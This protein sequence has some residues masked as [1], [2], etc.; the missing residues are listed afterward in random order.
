MAIHQIRSGTTH[1]SSSQKR[2]GRL[3]RTEEQIA[4]GLGW[5][6]IGL[7]LTEVLI[8]NI[9][10][11]TIGV[12]KKHGFLIRL[13]GLREITSGLG[14]FSRRRPAGW[15]WSRVVGDA[16]DLAMLG[17][18]MRSH[19]NNRAKVASATAAV[20]GVAALDFYDARKLSSVT[21]ESGKSDT[22]FVTKSIMINRS[23]EELYR[24]WHDFQ[25]LPRF[26]HNL[27]SVQLLGGNRT[28]WVAKG[29]GDKR[30]EWDAEIV[31]D[32]PNEMIT[33]RAVNGSQ[34]L[35]AG[36]VQFVSAPGGRGTK[37]VVEVQYEP[38]GGALGATVAKLFGKEP[39][40]RIQEDLRR[41]KQL[42]ETGEIP[43]TKGQPSGQRGSVSKFL[44]QAYNVN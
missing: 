20:L 43:T 28:H 30:I 32:S 27:D 35:N 16:M 31:S 40:H 3:V 37:V 25:N 11:K 33:W 29:P 14:I 5:F 24:F 34:I 10:A 38:P 13:L 7:G 22:V 2:E 42:M 44:K 17:G 9:L 39:A 12:R 15:V 8:P 26:M 4:R 41:F 23:A 19:K 36:S 18:A 21:G 1:E 6:S